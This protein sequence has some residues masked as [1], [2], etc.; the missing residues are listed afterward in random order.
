MVCGHYADRWQ[1]PALIDGCIALNQIALQVIVGPHA[2]AG[3]RLQIVAEIKPCGSPLATQVSFQFSFSL[4]R[5]CRCW[6]P[7]SGKKPTVQIGGS[8]TV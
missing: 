8:S 5:R 3:H 4:L 2:L 7:V 1:Q 6:S